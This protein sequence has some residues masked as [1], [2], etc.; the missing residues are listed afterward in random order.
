MNVERIELYM[1]SVYVRQKFSAMLTRVRRDRVEQSMLISK[2]WMRARYEWQYRIYGRR[3][4]NIQMSLNM[5]STE[6]SRA[7]LLHDYYYFL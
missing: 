6:E 4:G 2:E 3:N 5:V 7:H 1:R